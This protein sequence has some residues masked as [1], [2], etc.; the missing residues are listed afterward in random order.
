MQGDDIAANADLMTRLPVTV[1]FD[2]L[3]RIPQPA[4]TGHPAFAVIVAMPEK[5][6]AYVKLSSIYQDTKVGPPSYEDMGAL[7]RAYLKMAPDRVL[8]ASDWPHPSPGKF[9][10]PDDA[11]LVDLSAEW[12]S[13]DTTRQKIFVDNAA[14]LYGF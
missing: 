7:A 1:V 8:W 9:G 13:D 6:K 4:G 2:H 3:G 14:K 10:K 12:A 5:G 11:L